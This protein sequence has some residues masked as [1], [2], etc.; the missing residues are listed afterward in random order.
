MVVETSVNKTAE[1]GAKQ[2]HSLEVGSMWC[3]FT[4]DNRSISL[5]TVATEC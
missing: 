4:E 2:L 1:H 5:E 3:L